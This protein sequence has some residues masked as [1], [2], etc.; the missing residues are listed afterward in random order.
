MTAHRDLSRGKM[1]SPMM[2][3]PDDVPYAEPNGINAMI[4]TP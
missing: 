4:K 3:N 2:E 1:T